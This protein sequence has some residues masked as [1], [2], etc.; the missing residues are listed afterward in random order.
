[1]AQKPIT[2][3]LPED[4]LEA[5]KAQAEEGDRTFSRQVVSILRAHLGIPKPKVVER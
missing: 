3:R 5:L 1:M 4:L 2:I